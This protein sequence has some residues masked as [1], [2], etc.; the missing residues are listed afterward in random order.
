MEP[1]QTRSAQRETRWRK[2]GA[3]PQLL[4]RRGLGASGGEGV[5]QASP[6]TLRDSWKGRIARHLKLKSVK[7]KINRLHF[8]SCYADPELIEFPFDRNILHQRGAV[9]CDSPN[10]I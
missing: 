6:K 7:S 1:P 4:A 2:T 3:L 8:E 10:S 5:S 9:G